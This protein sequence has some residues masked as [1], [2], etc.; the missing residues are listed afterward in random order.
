MFC[1]NSFIHTDKYASVVEN[2]S[3]RHWSFYFHGFLN[4]IH[5]IT[6][7]ESKKG[8]KKLWKTYLETYLKLRKDEVKTYLEKEHKKK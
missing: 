8:C 4:L 5:N 1:S 6:N 2:V 3:Y 7:A